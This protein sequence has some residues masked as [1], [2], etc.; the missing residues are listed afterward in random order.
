MQ[1]TSCRQ[2]M[3][4]GRTATQSFDRMGGGGGQFQDPNEMAT[5]SDMVDCL[6]YTHF[7]QML[8][9]GRST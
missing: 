9:L 6:P 3:E 1:V 8:P 2:N 4:P 7:N 5:A